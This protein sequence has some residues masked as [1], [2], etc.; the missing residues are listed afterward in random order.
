MHAKSLQLWL[1]FCNS[2]DCS[3]PGFSVHGIFQARVLKWVSIFSSRG[4]PNPGIKPESLTL[5]ALAGGSFTTSTTWE[6]PYLYRTILSQF[7]P[8]TD[9]EWMQ[10]VS[11]LCQALTKFKHRE[12]EAKCIECL[13]YARSYSS[14]TLLTLSG[15]KQDHTW[16]WI[17][18]RHYSSMLLTHRLIFF[19]SLTVGLYQNSTWEYPSTILFTHSRS[20]AIAHWNTCIRQVLF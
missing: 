3:P 7:Y 11:S 10:W 1:T 15:R 18:A 17:Y 13:L 8:H 19:L 6:A 9:G 20:K 5:P 4:S 2:I 16:Y 12:Q 14:T